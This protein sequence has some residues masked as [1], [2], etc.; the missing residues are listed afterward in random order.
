M[1]LNLVR[2]LQLQY[3]RAP[4]NASPKNASPKNASPKNAS[5]KNASPKNASPK[6]GQAGVSTS[7]FFKNIPGW[8]VE[9]R[10]G[11]T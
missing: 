4:K 1:P 11:K 7:R 3:S 8:K 5:P 10:T 2:I 6:N 9:D